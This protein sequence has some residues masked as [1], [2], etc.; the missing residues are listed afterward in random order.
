MSLRHLS[1]QEYYLQSLITWRKRSPLS[2]CQC[3]HFA[4]LER[5]D[6]LL[7]LRQRHFKMIIAPIDSRPSVSESSWQLH[8]SLALV[9][10]IITEDISEYRT[11]TFHM[12]VATI[13]AYNENSFHQIQASTSLACSQCLTKVRFQSFAIAMIWDLTHQTFIATQYQMASLEWLP[14]SFAAHNGTQIIITQASTSLALFTV[15]TFV[16]YLQ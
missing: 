4:N 7:N 2:I 3:F 5:Q 6:I 11:T 15:V 13:N 9:V 10:S 16:N 14:H 12:T 8:C 1:P